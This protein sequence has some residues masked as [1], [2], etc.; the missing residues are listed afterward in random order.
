MMPLNHKPTYSKKNICQKYI[1]FYYQKINLNEKSYS[2]IEVTD[3][4]ILEFKQVK[5][6]YVMVPN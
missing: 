6:L 4:N 2:I 5:F 1:C 3:D